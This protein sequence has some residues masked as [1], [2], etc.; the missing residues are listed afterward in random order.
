MTSNQATTAA[1]AAPDARATVPL[2]GNIHPLG[3]TP[4][5]QLGKV[6]PCYPT[7]AGN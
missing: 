6:G 1:R 2:P 4:G 7:R 5:E 3:R